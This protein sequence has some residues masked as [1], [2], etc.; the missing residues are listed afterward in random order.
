MLLRPAS[1]TSVSFPHSARTWCHEQQHRPGTCAARRLQI[2]R[3][4]L[5]IDGRSQPAPGHGGQLSRHTEDHNLSNPQNLDLHDGRLPAA[6][7]D[8]C[9]DVGQFAL[10]HDQRRLHHAYGRSISPVL[11][12]MGLGAWH[13]VCSGEAL[14]MKRLTMRQNKVPLVSPCLKSKAPGPRE[15]SST[16][17]FDKLLVMHY[18]E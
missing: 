18:K 11:S 7:S 9:S 2:S 17:V 8:N 3:T 14:L 4:H 6:C 10:E 13:A 1:T 12:R 16:S 15:Q 5:L